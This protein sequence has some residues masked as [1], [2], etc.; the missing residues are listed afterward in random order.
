MLVTDKGIIIRFG[1]ETVSQTGRSTMGVR[2]IKLDD[3]SQVATMAKVAKEDSDDD[4]Q[5]Q[6]S[7]DTEQ[8][9]ATKANP[10]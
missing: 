10:E 2:L 6:P 9:D 4:N 1:I 8:A 5:S 7:A 3:N